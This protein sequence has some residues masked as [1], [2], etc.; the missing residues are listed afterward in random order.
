VARQGKRRG[1]AMA[2][3]SERAQE[4]ER[5]SAS[6]WR[7]R[8]VGPGGEPARVAAAAGARRGGSW[9]A[10]RCRSVGH[11]PGGALAKEQASGRGT[12]CSAQAGTASVGP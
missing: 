1:Q 8:A 9:Q 3:A 6:G 4:P 12:R 2:Q 7:R 11:G 10:A 5:R